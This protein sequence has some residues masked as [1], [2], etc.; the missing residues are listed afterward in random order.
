M[1]SNLRSQDVP[2]VTQT[3]PIQ[4]SVVWKPPRVG[5]FKLNFDAS[6]RQGTGTGMGMIVRD[7]QGQVLVAA[8][9]LS[10]VVMEIREVEATTFRWAI[11]KAE[12]D[13]NDI[14]ASDEGNDKVKQHPCDLISLTH[15]H[16]RM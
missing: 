9:Y 8:T 15:H 6:V 4:G 11:I 12:V 3:P 7:H 13:D 5:L 14:D 2:Q 1:F 10:D 16:L